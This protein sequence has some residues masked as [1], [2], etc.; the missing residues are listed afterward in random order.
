[1]ANAVSTAGMH[2]KYAA[3]ASGTTRPTSAYIDIP[4]CKSIPSIFNEPNTL[5][6]TSLNAERNH[7]YIM[8]LADSG[9][10]IAVTVNDYSAFRT[11]WESC[12]S[13]YQ[14]AMAAEKGFWFEIAYPEGTGL[15]SFYFMGEPL[16]LGFGG[17]EVDSVLENNAN[18]LPQGDFI[19]A[20]ASG[21]SA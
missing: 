5:Q 21:T 6:S 3:S 1:M 11:A 17:A 12:V 10:S 4:G 9:G 13:A 16:P 18:I 8:G 7:T 15:D 19:F 14:T 20:A 2:L